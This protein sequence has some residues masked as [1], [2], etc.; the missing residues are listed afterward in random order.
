MEYI[1]G[2]LIIRPIPE[3]DE[4]LFYKDEDGNVRYNPACEKCPKDCKQSFRISKLL[5]SMNK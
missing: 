5:C 3:V 2:D 4:M 1:D